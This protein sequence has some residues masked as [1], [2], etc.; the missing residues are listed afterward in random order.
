M[1]ESGRTFQSNPKGD[2]DVNK[3]HLLK[4]NKVLGTLVFFAVFSFGWL[5]IP[6]KYICWVSFPVLVWGAPIAHLGERQ[7]WSQGCGF[8]P[9]GVWLLLDQ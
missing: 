1:R 9:F 3:K 6:V 8:N 4:K 2:N 5:Y 7:T